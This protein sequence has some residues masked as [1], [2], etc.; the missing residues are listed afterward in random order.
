M[1]GQCSRTRL[2]TTTQEICPEQS[3]PKCQNLSKH[4]TPTQNSIHEA[5]VAE[6]IILY[7][8]AGKKESN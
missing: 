5:D 8:A 2:A 6:K 1:A 4:K 3:T 7:T